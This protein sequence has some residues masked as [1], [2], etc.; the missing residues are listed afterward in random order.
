MVKSMQPEEDGSVVIEGLNLD[1]SNH[2]LYAARIVSQANDSK[3]VGGSLVGPSKMAYD[4]TT[5]QFKIKFDPLEEEIFYVQDPKWLELFTRKAQIDRIAYGV[6]SEERIRVEQLVHVTR[7]PVEYMPD[8]RVV[9]EDA[10]DAEQFE[11]DM[12]ERAERAEAE[13]LVR[14]AARLAKKEEKM[15]RDAARQ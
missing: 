13:R 15:K 4:K 8:P 14:E 6:A 11:R 2:G 9:K 12:K 7:L 5:H 10:H 1:P 3:V